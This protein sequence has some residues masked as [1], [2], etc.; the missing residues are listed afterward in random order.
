MNKL[1][2][3]SS[4]G[5]QMSLAGWTRWWGPLVSCSWRGGG[6]GGEGLCTVRSNAAWVMVTW[7]PPL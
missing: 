5:Q 2:Q 7:D 4:D 3:V 1:E 6:V